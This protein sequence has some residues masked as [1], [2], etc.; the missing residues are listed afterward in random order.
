MRL[1]GKVISSPFLRVSTGKEISGAVS[2][3]KT[4]PVF[5]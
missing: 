3:D 5:N 1:L 4:Q 2:R